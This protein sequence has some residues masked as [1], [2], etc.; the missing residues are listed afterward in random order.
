MYY[1]GREHGGLW[2]Q[3][4]IA[5]RLLGARVKLLVTS[6][7]FTGVEY[8]N[9]IFTSMTAAVTLFLMEVIYH[10]YTDDT[11]AQ[12]TLIEQPLLQLI[13]QIMELLQIMRQC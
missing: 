3:T 8:S 6:L 5:T 10:N 11:S 2:Q 9:L 1:H 4:A 12:Y 13:H 7:K